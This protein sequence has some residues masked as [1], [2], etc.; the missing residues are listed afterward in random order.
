MTDVLP[1]YDI[2]TPLECRFLQLGLNDTYLVKTR[3]GQYILRVCR[4]GWRSVSGI[5]YELDVLLFSPAG[6]P[7]G[8]RPCAQKRRQPYP[9]CHRARRHTVRGPVYARTRQRA[10]L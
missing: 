2:G 8:V 9:S 5:L 4:A 6:E 3:D 10:E 1:D 7:C